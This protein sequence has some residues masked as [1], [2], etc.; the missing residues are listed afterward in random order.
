MVRIQ[1]HLT[2]AQDRQLRALARKRG[3]T[4]AELIRRGVERVLHEDD[5]PHDPL[6]ELLGAAGG[7]VAPDISERHDEVLYRAEEPRLL[8]AAEKEPGE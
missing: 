4:R 5:S 8:R 7:A 1:L 3:L 6:L 2:E